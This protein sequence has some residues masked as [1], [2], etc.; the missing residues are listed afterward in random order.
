MLVKA[1]YLLKPLIPRMVQLHLRR[2]L[3][4]WRR[5][6]LR[7]VW[8]VDERAGRYPSGWPGWPGGKRFALVLTHDVDT[9]A[10]QRKCLDLMAME[11]GLGFVSSFNFV[12]KRY[13]VCPAVRYFLARGGFEVGVHGLY[14]DGKYFLSRDIFRRRAVQINRYLREWGSVGF[15]TP[16]MLNRLE[17][18][19]DLDIAYDTSTFDT[20]PFEP[21]PIGAGTIFPF[22]VEGGMARR[23]FVELPYT[24]PQ[25][26]TLFV[27]MKETGISIWKKKLDWIADKGGMALLSTHPDY[28]SFDGGRLGTE[29]YPANH[30]RDILSYA[31]TAYAGR[32]W[33]ALPREVAAFFRE[34]VAAAA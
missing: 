22:W 18:F 8:P 4:L 32:Y 26:F 24:M 3:V 1:F 21:Q 12:P 11:K 10:G 7:S 23:G 31:K 29:E 17:W 20:D 15:R 25:D 16:S 33:H 19:H 13:T 34:A 27:L 14:H 30:Y 5:A 2:K 9:A 6:K 28:M